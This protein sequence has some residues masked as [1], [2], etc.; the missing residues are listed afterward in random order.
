ME[1]GTK[2]ADCVEIN[3]NVLLVLVVTQVNMQLVTPV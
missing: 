2:D 1:V 3:L